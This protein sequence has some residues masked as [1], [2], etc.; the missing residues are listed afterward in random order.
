MRLRDR[1]LSITAALLVLAFLTPGAA[2][3]SRGCPGMPAYDA[4]AEIAVTGTVDAIDQ[5][6]CARVGFGL[7]LVIAGDDGTTYEAHLGPAAFAE[8]QG[9]VFAEG[10]RVEVIGVETDWGDTGALLAREVTR[11]GATLTLRDRD[12]RPQWAGRAA[13]RGAGR[14]AGRG[15]CRLP[16][17]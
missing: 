17:R 13:G 14:R 3:A 11:E 12:G 1:M 10:D 2:G 5:P 8:E 7:H 9:F 16:A 4:T 15:G 6:E